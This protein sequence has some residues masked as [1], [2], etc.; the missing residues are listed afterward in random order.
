MVSRTLEKHR[1]WLT[2]LPCPVIRLDGACPLSELVTQ[3]V[4]AIGT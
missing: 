2:S 3:V 4:A 1:M